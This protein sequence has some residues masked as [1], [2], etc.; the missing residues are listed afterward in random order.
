MRLAE[1]L[2]G[3]F[4]MLCE[5]LGRSPVRVKWVDAKKSHFTLRFLGEINDGQVESIAESLLVA[6]SDVKVFP[7]TVHGVGA[8]PKTSKPNVVWAGIQPAAGPMA[9]LKLAVDTALAEHG[10]PKERRV[11][12]PHF[13]LGRVRD[14]AVAG[15]LAKPLRKVADAHLGKMDVK[16][17]AFIKS[18]L[19]PEGP[20][21]EDL[22]VI[23]L[24]QSNG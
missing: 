14:R 6:I 9:E 16:E 12:R 8:F 3:P 21:Y 11:Y 2:H 15:Q 20:I 5:E 23:P 18:T 22:T 4:N 1:K 19:T 17:V 7:I 13:T 10:F 24:G